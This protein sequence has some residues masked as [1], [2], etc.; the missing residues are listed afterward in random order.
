MCLEILNNL[1][2]HA[3][4]NALFV[5]VS[6]TQDELIISLRH[7]GK[8]VTNEEIETFTRLSTG[9][10][11]KSLR[12]RAILLNAGIIYEKGKN[13]STVSLTVPLKA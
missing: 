1:R 10:G 2:K 12:S 11:L 9:L 8:G 3:K 6:N 13:F 5:E 7:D 4:Y